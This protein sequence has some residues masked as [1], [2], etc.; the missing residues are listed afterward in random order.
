M[1][2]SIW[3]IR[4]DLRLADNPALA[5]ARAQENAVLPVFIQDPALHASPY[6]S[7]RRWQFLLGSLHTLDQELRRLGSQLF[8]LKGRPQA[9]LS[10]LIQNSYADRIDAEED[11]SPYATRRDK[12]VASVVPLHLHSGASLLPPGTIA[13]RSGKPFRVYTPFRNALL[14]HPLSRGMA[15]LNPP[16]SLSLPE[17][18]PESLPIPETSSVPAAFPP[19]AEE[20]LRRLAAFTQRSGAIGQYQKGRNALAS[21][22]TSRLSP[23]LRFGMLSARQAFLVASRS[24]ENAADDEHASIQTWRDQLIWRDFFINI[25]AANPTVRQ[26]SFRSEFRRIA[27]LN[28]EDEFVAWKQG[29]TGYPLIDA[30][31]RQLLEEGWIPNRA[32]MVVASFLVKHLLID[33]RWGERWF[34][35][36]LLDGDPAQ[37][38]GGWQWSAGTG[39]DAAPYFRIF[40]PI[41]QSRQYDPKGDYIR[42]W[43]PELARIP[44]KLIHEPWRLS[45]EVRNGYPLPLVDHPFA[46]ERALETYVQARRLR[47]D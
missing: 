39:T 23:Y 11:H 47:T 18:I 22:E 30:A 15:P 8:Y 37:N 21:P 3:W 42:R 5:A 32:R 4:R 20:A 29:R 27:W 24:L 28:R 6:F 17:R 35:Q 10:D 46:R 33:W 25:L 43:L 19:G 40:N 16:E 31:M 9:V 41:L 34:M 45:D 1:T 12:A 38:N 26:M 2:T 44:H 7:P 36:H 13:T 14:A